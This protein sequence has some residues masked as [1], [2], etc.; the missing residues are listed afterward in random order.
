[1]QIRGMQMTKF[2]SPAIASEQ[3]G[4]TVRYLNQLV[5]TSKDWKVNVHY[6]DV[7]S[8]MAERPS[9]QYNLEEINKWFAVKPEKRA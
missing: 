3:L 2:V 9:Y 8:P 6:R 5:K 1:M 7:R 4:V